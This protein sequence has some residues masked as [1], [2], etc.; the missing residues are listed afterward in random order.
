MVKKLLGMATIGLFAS[1]A[2]ASLLLYEPFNY[3][4]GDL[5]LNVA[6]NGNTWYSSATSGTTDFVQVTN[7]GSLTA[8]VV[9]SPFPSPTGATAGNHV[10]FG[11][12]GRTDRVG[13]AAQTTGTVWYSLL[14]KIN[15]LRN[16]GASGGAIVGFN[17][18]Q[19]TA[20]NDLTAA[21]PSNIED[22]V[23]IKTIA[24]DLL[25]VGTFQIGLDKGTG[26]A[27]NFVFDSGTYNTGDTVLIVGNYQFNSGTTT[28]D[29]TR[30]WINPAAA[31]LGDDGLTPGAN[32]TNST[33]TDNGQLAAFILR[34]TSAV[35]PAGIELD[36]L[37]IGTTWTDVTA[38]PEPTTAGLLG[39]GAMGLLSRRKRR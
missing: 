17:N 21:Q 36:E 34:Q 2:S 27:A 4:A 13:F 1:Q 39:V 32:L 23:L 10:A 7:T 14:L 11:N 19:Q 15:D 30:L 24:A 9:S 12:T 35:V 3:A 33:G 31:T 22:R 16:T 6:P 37:R 8:P 5:H 28:D 25:G 38:V 20:V 26:T 18:T 29:T